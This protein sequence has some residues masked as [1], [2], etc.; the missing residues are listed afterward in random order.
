M[1]PRLMNSL[2]IAAIVNVVAL[3]IFLTLD[4]TA[5]LPVHHD[6]ITALTGVGSGC[7]VGYVACRVGDHITVRVLGRLDLIEGRQREI[8]AEARQPE[9]LAAL[10]AVADVLD[11]RVETRVAEERIAELRNLAP[12]ANGADVT[13][14]RSV[15]P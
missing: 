10:A 7:G 6:I 9:T 13:R 15:G 4:V 12:N 8:L 2:G 3:V 5:T 1:S 14:L 11:E